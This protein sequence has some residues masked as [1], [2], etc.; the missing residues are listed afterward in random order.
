MSS[1]MQS[2]LPLHFGLSE[3]SVPVQ[4][5]RPRRK[6]ITYAVNFWT[7]NKVE[8]VEEMTDDWAAIGS[9]LILSMTSLKILRYLTLLLQFLFKR[10]I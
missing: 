6:N 4:P 1:V 3:N 8:S 5:G 2:G 7:G 10:K 9:T